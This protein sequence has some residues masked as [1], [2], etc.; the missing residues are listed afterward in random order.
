MIIGHELT[1]GFDDE[2]RQYDPEGNLKDWWTPEDGKAFE[3]RADVHRRAVFGLYAPVAG[4]PP[5]RQAH[6]RRERGR[7][8][9]PPHRLRRAD[10]TPSG[11]PE[12]S[13]PID[14]F[15]PRSASS[16]AWPGLVRELDGRSRRGS[17]QD[18][19]HTVEQ[20][21]VNGVPVSNMP[22]FR[23]AFS[24]KVGQPMAPANA[25]RVW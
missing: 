6:P 21:R 13:R 25:C 1:H 14:G 12:P 23:E 7:Q 2:G 16:W 24:C 9:R 8:R 3:E 15:T 20:F 19:E 4:P 17:S 5:Q 18:D 22:E 10:A 11:K